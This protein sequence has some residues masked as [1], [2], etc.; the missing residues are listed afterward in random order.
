MLK[1]GCFFCLIFYLQFSFS[2]KKYTVSGVIHTGNDEKLANANV[3][4]LKAIDSSFVKGTITGIN[5]SYF[6]KDI[7]KGN[8]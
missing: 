3:L 1:I 8:S 7:T 4:L 5:G 6:L 2:Q